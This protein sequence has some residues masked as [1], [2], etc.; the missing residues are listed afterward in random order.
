MLAPWVYAPPP[1]LQPSLLA[2]RLVQSTPVTVVKPV[3]PGLTTPLSHLPAILSAVFISQVIHEVGHAIS[4][5]LDAVPIVSAGASFTIAI[6]AA[7]VS[8]PATTLQALQPYSRARII[9][10]GPFHN[11]VFWTVLLTVDWLG[12]AN[13]FNRDVSDIGRVVVNIDKDSDL[14]SYIE[15]G[16]IIT[17]IDD[18]SLGSPEDIWTSYLTSISPPSPGWCVKHAELTTNPHSCC[19]STTS[20]PLACFSSTMHHDHGCL[21]PV[22]VLTSDRHRCQVDEECPSEMLCVRP[23]DSANFVRIGVGDKT[24]L[25]SGPKNEI[26]DQVEI[27]SRIPLLCPF[28]LVQH[29][30]LFWSY[31]KMATLSLF[32][33]NLLPLPYLDG[34]QFMQALLDMSLPEEHEEYDMN[35]LESGDR[36]QRSRRDRWKERA[37]R[38]IGTV[39]SGLF[40]LSVVFALIDMR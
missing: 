21:D 10:A 4:A 17:K 13:S 26:Y 32:L 35:A 28:W 23:R 1:D 8:F 36:R 39:T 30:T 3:I 16:S 33:F 6:P 7:F 40:V 29:L 25:W 31:L 9:A 2:K 14:G 19:Q 34:T 27:G 12:L 38:S 5:A 37:G 15:L 18:V 11:L 20:S 24:I 22:S